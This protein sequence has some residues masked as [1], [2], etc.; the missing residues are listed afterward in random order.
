MNLDKA[1]VMEL[2][3]RVIEKFGCQPLGTFL[4]QSLNPKGRIMRYS[5]AVILR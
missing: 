3:N 5:Y 2:G 4:A 1:P